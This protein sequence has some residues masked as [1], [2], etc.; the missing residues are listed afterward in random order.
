[1]PETW[2][3]LD[4]YVARQQAEAG[5]ILQCREYLLGSTSPA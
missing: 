2:P 1:M 3:G 4:P 5:G